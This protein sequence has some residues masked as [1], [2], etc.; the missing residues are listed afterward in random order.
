MRRSRFAVLVTLLTT[1]L[2]GSSVGAQTP[3]A[4]ALIGK[5]EGQIRF[6]SSRANPGRTLIIE[7]VGSGEGTVPVRGRYGVTGQNLGRMQ[8]TLEI[9]DGR[10]RLRFTTGAN[11]T[12]VLELQGDKDLVGTIGLSGEGDR[13][14]RLK[15]VE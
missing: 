4:Q 3:P 15:K 9:A 6:Q 11:S 2:V 7:S 5:W 13:E 10:P 8:G 14:M 1:V 12:V